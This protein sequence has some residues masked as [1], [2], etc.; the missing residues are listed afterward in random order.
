MNSN[1]SKEEV[2]GDVR[3]GRNAKGWLTT[4]TVEK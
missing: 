2:S 4:M 3:G 1:K